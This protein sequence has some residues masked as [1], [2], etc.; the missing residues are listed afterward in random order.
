MFS[1]VLH[2]QAPRAA[3][4]LLAGLLTAAVFYAEYVSLGVVLGAALPG[5]AGPA[6]GS[7]MVVGAVLVN[8]AIGAAL[9]Q[10]LLAGPRAASLAVLVAG[11]KLAT[12]Q[13]HEAA[14]RLPVA[15]TAL[16]VMLVVG[17]VVQLAGLLPRV[18]AWL[19]CTSVALR[20]GFVFSTAVGIVVGLGAG[21]L[22]GCLRVSPL[23]TCLV[24][25]AAVAASLVWS[26]VCRGPRSAVPAARSRWRGSLAPF[27]LLVGIAVAWVG[28]WLF[29]APA[30][31]T[32]TTGLTAATGLCGLVGGADIAAPLAAWPW[33]TPATLTK[34]HLWLPLWTW[35]ALIALGG[36]LGLVLLLESLTMLRESRDQTPSARWGRQLKAR[37]L[38]N[39]LAAPFG[40]ACSSLAIARTNALIE[41]G[42]RSRLAVLLHGVALAGIVLYMQDWIAELPQLAVAAALLLLAM[43]LIDDETR[44]QVWRA[45][46]APHAAPVDV[47][48]AWVFWG[49]V[50]V[51]TA[52]GSLLHYQGWGFGGGPLIAFFVGTAWT[53]QR[54]LRRRRA[55]ARARHSLLPP[56]APGRGAPTA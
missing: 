47:R 29:V 53:A 8:C 12:A 16:A 7:L 5:A 1:L 35:L 31:A 54:F 43:Q 45:G 37:A 28:Y 44:D 40:L 49:V 32:L 14:D 27:S 55:L 30:A 2:P 25:A 15:L 4:D 48:A 21:Q 46:Y 11:L 34:A 26:R 17:A 56:L 39:L 50:V 42:G 24:M 3:G 18:R 6:L 51:S 10:P 52:L 38:A 41:C 36:L 33:M 19:C 13:V 23:A 22:D 20:K 9:R